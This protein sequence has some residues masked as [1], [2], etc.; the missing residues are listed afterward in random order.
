MMTPVDA[1]RH[2]AERLM[3]GATWND[4][5]ESRQA[6]HDALVAPEWIDR[7]AM[8]LIAV[9]IAGILAMRDQD[10]ESVRHA[11]ARERVWVGALIRRPDLDP[12]PDL[13]L[14]D[15]VDGHARVALAARANVRA[16]GAVATIDAIREEL[17][18]TEVWSAISGDRARSDRG[19]L[20]ALVEG[21]RIDLRQMRRLGEAIRAWTQHFG[22]AAADAAHGQ[23]PAE[24]AVIERAWSRWQ[25]ESRRGAQ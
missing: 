5:A 19:W 16:R 22:H 8:E 24:A 9:E 2:V 11:C 3:A 25:A 15:L 18:R 7:Q 12:D 21:P 20:D 14:D 10:D 17:R 1:A 4:A 13:G 6:L 23:T